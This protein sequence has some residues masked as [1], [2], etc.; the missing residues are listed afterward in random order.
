[1]MHVFSLKIR[2]D[3]TYVNA[4]QFI[5]AFETASRVYLLWEMFN[6]KRYCPIFK[7]RYIF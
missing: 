2:K 4:L 6:C 7:N 3:P 1:M 5:A